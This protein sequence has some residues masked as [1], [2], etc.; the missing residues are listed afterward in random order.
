MCSCNGAHRLRRW[1][2]IEKNAAPTIHLQIDEAG[3]EHCGWRHHFG[4]PV[5]RILIMRHDALNHSTI[6]QDDRIL[7]PSMSV[8]NT[9]SRDCR[10]GST[11]G[12]GWF[13]SHR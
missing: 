7:V 6:D 3:R 8:E 10:P 13:Q 5:T 11:G 12:F 4:W 1:L 9:V 2:I